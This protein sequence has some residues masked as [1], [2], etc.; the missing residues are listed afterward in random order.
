[1][2]S[3]ERLFQRFIFSTVISARVAMEYKVSPL[4][5]LYST[6]LLS[7]TMICS[8]GI[9]CSGSLGFSSSGSLGGGFSAAGGF[10]ESEPF[11]LPGISV[12]GELTFS[13]P[14]RTGRLKS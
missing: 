6:V 4:T 14:L 3:E 1:M 7:P 13:P 11:P 12:F 8:G 5:T 10:S 9:G 2:T